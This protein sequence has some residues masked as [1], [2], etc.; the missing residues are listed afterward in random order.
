V[1]RQVRVG[2]ELYQLVE[3]VREAG[4]ESVM[5]VVEKNVADVT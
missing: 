1:P 3:I 4:G 5:T 2:A